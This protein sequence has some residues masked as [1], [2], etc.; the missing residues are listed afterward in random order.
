MLFCT[1]TGKLQ[2]KQNLTS[3][4][5]VSRVLHARV[6]RGIVRQSHVRGYGDGGSSGFGDSSS[7]SEGWGDGSNDGYGRCLGFGHG[8]GASFPTFKELHAS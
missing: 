8:W 1:H 2:F 6:S 5:K 3:M 7:Y 4:P